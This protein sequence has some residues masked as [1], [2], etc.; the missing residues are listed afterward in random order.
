MPRVRVL[1]TGATGQIGYMTFKRLLEQPERYEVFGLDRKLDPSERVPVDWRLEIP[2]DRFTVGDLSDFETVRAAVDSMD[3]VAHLGADPEGREWD[4]VLQN[5]I[6]GTYNVFEAARQADVRRVVAASSIMVSE[7]HRDQEPHKAMMERRLSDIPDEIQ[8][9]S[10]SIPAEPRGIYGASKVWTE[11]L[12]RVYSNTRGL[13]CICVRIGQVERDRP[14]P[15]Q[16]ADIYVSQRDIVQAIEKCINA[17]ENVQFG[18]IYGMSN[19]DHRWVD[20]SGAKDLVGF[21][22]LDRAEDAHTYEDR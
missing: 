12:A 19:N 13:S 22:P 16:G 5:N 11:S 14:R 4:S 17:S 20:I 15:P 9:V 7:G 18:I 3:V 10:P 8:F 1:V 6:V 2:E 21:E